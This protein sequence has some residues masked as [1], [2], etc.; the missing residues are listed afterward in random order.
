M[1]VDLFSVFFSSVSGLS[2][3]VNLKTRNDRYLLL[4]R[5]INGYETTD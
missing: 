1:L 2:H 5:P 4:G 3:E